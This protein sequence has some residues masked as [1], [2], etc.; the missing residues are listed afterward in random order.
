[1]LQLPPQLQR[2]LHCRADTCAGAGSAADTGCEWTAA[3]D[4]AAGAAGAAAAGDVGTLP[5]CGVSL[6]R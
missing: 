5:P 3:A 4:A 1:M 6:L 2:A